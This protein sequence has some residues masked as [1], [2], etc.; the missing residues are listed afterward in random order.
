MSLIISLS[1][2]CVYL[3]FNLSYRTNFNSFDNL[4]FETDNKIIHILDKDKYSVDNII[5]TKFS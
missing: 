2:L 3:V 5:P 1:V 4:Y